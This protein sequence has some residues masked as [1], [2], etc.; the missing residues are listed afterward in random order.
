MAL[1]YELSPE[2]RKFW[3]LLRDFWAVPRKL[4]RKPRKY[5]GSFWGKVP[6]FVFRFGVGVGAERKL[7]WWV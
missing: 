5:L 2:P 7:E 3:L 1:T 4:L 6:R